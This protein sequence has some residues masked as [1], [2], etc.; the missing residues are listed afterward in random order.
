VRTGKQIRIKSVAG[1]MPLWA[2]IAT[3]QQAKR[4]V[5]HL[6]NPKEFWTPYPVPSYARSER[7]YTQH[8]VPPPLL[9]PYYGLDDGHSNWLG[10]VWGHTNY[11]IVHGLQHYGFDREARTIAQKSYEMSAPDMQIREFSNAETG[12]GSG[13]SW[14]CAGAE[15]SLRL[16]QAELTAN[17]S[18]MPIEDASKPI[19][20]DRVR[21]ALGLTR[22][23]RQKA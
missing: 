12:V 6:T 20:S 3:E 4:L 16:L 14:I 11:F 23:F 8:H 22:K 7:N 13:G 9:D 18:P 17:F 5:E 10:G 1:F 19:S 15:L 2:G 21:A